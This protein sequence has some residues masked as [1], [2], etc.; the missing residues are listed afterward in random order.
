MLRAHTVLGGAVMEEDGQNQVSAW[1]LAWTVLLPFSVCFFLSNYYRSV[2]AILS[3][4]LLSDLH[5]AASNLGFLTSAYFFTTAVFQLPLGLL[6]DRYGPRRVQASLMGIASI[7]VLVFAVSAHYP[8]L[9]FGRAIMG[10]GAAGALMTAFQAVT[11]WYAKQHWPL[12]NGFVLGA[13]GLGAL[14]ATLPTELILHVFDWRH[15]MLGVA[16]AS[17]SA[18]ALVFGLAPERKVEHARETMREQLRGVAKV[19]RS[20]L[21]LCIMPL[22]A[23]TVGSNLAF[24]GL[25]AG[26]WLKDVAHLSASHVA[27]GLLVVSVLQTISYV[28]VGWLAGVL[29]KHG[30]GFVRIIGS[31]TFLF[32]ATQVGLLLPTGSA[33]WM[34]LI[35]M[36]LL[37]NVNLLSY[38]LLVQNLPA[39]VTGRANTA[40]NFSVFIGAFFLQYIVGV[41]IDMF[42]PIALTTYPPLAYQIAFA[43]MFGLQTASW[44]WFVVSSRRNSMSAS[45]PLNHQ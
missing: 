33:R 9:V 39:S 42:A 19:C 17:L 4:R 18:S 26:P 16:I 35:G 1:Q 20:S 2:N 28:I 45:L 30:I 25:W 34:V 12:L 43:F 37:A 15:L 11:L 38:P 7:G 40:L 31:G 24:Q 27:R 6:M 44:I 36:G 22:Y 23:M 5:L 14:A 21:F 10:I 3:P 32:V 8:V 13:G 29:S 41:L